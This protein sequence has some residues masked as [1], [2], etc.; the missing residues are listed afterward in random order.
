[1]I[2]SFIEACCLEFN[3]SHNIIL[4]N[5]LMHG[6]SVEVA[7]WMHIIPLSILASSCRLAGMSLILHY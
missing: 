4:F 7:S 2:I 6:K 5:S 3:S 1:M